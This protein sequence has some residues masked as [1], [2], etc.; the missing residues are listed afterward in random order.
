MHVYRNTILS[1]HVC[2]RVAMLHY[3]LY[4]RDTAQVY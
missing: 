2:V 1:M 4:F 3:R